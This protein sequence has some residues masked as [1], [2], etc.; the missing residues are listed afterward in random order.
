M[1]KCAGVILAGGRGERLG[2]ENK[3]LLEVG[4]TRLIDRM[5]E[6]L[7]AQCQPVAVSVKTS[8]AWAEHLKIPAL[9]D[10]RTDASGP[11]A[12]IASA[13]HWSRDLAP[14]VDWV[15]TVPVDIPFIPADLIE[16]LTLQDSDVA[17][18][19]SAGQHHHAIAAWR[20]HLS[21]RAAE[22]IGRGVRAV[23]A[24][25]AELQRRVVTWPSTPHDPFLNI[26]TPR[27]LERAQQR[28]TV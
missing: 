14:H 8:A 24:F 1:A 3:A 6:R 19:M 7:A 5:I 4:G 22:A 15:I 9:C 17:I 12:G 25:Q 26:N 10:P 20:P 2:G 11:L 16:R 18:A 27:D 21:E 13:L 23:R 28:S